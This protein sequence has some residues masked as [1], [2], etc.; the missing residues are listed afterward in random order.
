MFTL[1]LGVRW[2]GL[3][4][5]F[6]GACAFPVVAPPPFLLTCQRQVVVGAMVRVLLNQVLLLLLDEVLAGVDGRV[7]EE[8][9]EVF[10]EVGGGGVLVDGGGVRGYSD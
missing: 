3:V 2:V 1:R 9:E 6:Y 10:G 8:G 7:G 4:L 5:R